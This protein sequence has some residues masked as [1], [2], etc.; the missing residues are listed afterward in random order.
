MLLSFFCELCGKIGN[1]MPRK[2]KLWVTI[3]WVHLEKER[4]GRT[5]LIETSRGIEVADAAPFGEEA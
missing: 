3:R 2:T 5:S 4:W 1:E